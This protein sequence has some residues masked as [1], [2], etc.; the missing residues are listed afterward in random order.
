MNIKIALKS[1]STTRGIKYVDYIVKNDIKNLNDLI[2]NLVNIEIDKY[3]VEK[4]IEVLSQNDI[5]NMVI[6]GKISFGFKYR[7]VEIDRE[8]AQ[9][10]AL[11]AFKDGLFAV[12]INNDEIKA[13]DENL[14]LKNNDIVTFIRF[15]MLTGRYY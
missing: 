10:V 12:F 6:S 7:E 3:E 8:N 1:V 13:L 14:S 2:V 4:E 15:T 5:D 9:D 11:L